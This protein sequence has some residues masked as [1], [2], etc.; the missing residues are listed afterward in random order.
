MATATEMFAEVGYHRT[1][2]SAL[3]A[4]LGVG[5]GVFYWKVPSWRSRRIPRPESKIA[6]RYPDSKTASFS[7]RLWHD[8]V[9]TLP[10]RNLTPQGVNV[11]SVPTL[12]TLDPVTVTAMFELGTASR[13][14]HN[15]HVDPGGPANVSQVHESS[16]LFEWRVFC[17]V[18]IWSQAPPRSGCDRVGTSTRCTLYKSTTYYAQGPPAEARG[19]GLAAAP[20][21]PR[22]RTA[23]TARYPTPPG[24]GVTACRPFEGAYSHLGP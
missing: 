5:K 6:G 9:R 16:P 17:G 21:Q 12:W 19:P 1:S 13:A 18:S 15:E 4:G 20:N 3:V 14:P 8:G 7:V 2:V 11:S 23:L 24:L 22:N 10:P